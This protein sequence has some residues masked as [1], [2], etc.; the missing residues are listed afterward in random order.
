MRRLRCQDARHG[1]PALAASL[2]L[3]FALGSFTATGQELTSEADSF[4][5]EVS[6]RPTSRNWKLDDFSG[7][8]PALAGTRSF[9]RGRLAFDAALCAVC[10]R[11]GEHGGDLG[12]DLAKPAKPRTRGELLREILEP[13]RDIEPKYRTYAIT[14]TAGNVIAGLIVEQTDLQVT[15]RTR[16]VGDGASQTIPRAE[17]D[18]IEQLDLSMMPGEL[19]GR[20]TKDEVLD[21]L[22]YVEAQG[23]PRSPL[24]RRP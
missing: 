1:L 2:L 9:E 11:I 17:I 19:M 5:A 21:L 7:D 15:V 12:P 6:R 16:P 23:D 10:H 18:S 8:L 14:T 24:F 13:S 3:P 4:S 22:A 20:L